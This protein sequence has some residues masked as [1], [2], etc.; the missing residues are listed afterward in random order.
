MIPPLKLTSPRPSGDN[1]L[2]HLVLSRRRA[3]VSRRSKRYAEACEQ[4]IVV[5][6]NA[7]LRIVWERAVEQ[8]PFY[9]MWADRHKLPS[10]IREVRELE[11]FPPLTKDDL[12][13]HHDLV[14]ARSSP[15]RVYSTGGSTGTPVHYPRG[16]GEALERYAG[17]FVARSWYGIEPGDPYV[18][19]WGASHRFGEGRQAVIRQ[20][21]R[22]LLNWGLGAVR[23]NAYDL[24]PEMLVEHA[25][26]VWETNPV[27]IAGYSSSVVR[28]ARTA[29]SQGL[30]HASL[31]RLKA[32]L[33]SAEAIS[34]VD[35]DVL[36]EVFGVP[37]I[38]E[39]GSAETGA[40]AVSSGDTWPL[41]V[42]WDSV[43]VT[44]G[45]ESEIHVT[46]L[47]SRAFPLINYRIGDRATGLSM[48]QGSALQIGRIEGR[49][50]D[51]LRLRREDGGQMVASAILPTHILKG[52]PAI[53]SV[54]IYCQNEHV[55]FYITADELLDASGVKDFF[56]T[57]VAHD[58]TVLDP[59]FLHVVQM[60]RPHLTPGGK[61]LLMI[62]RPFTYPN[63]GSHE[64]TGSRRD[65]T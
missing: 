15:A 23:L 35:I 34:D 59:T 25:R 41:R 45:E 33:V 51:D 9:R 43:A 29:R 61:Q 65:D 1:P 18:H 49:R 22:N 6:Q 20:W 13:E 44:P 40:I 21:R 56:L 32:V 38:N 50:Q 8:Q 42:L 10:R 3:A 30:D 63:V 31:T 28:V 55:T 53:A 62:T 58:G 39:Y 60:E 46:T 36:T 7:M 64:V 52:L 17:A 16:R 14:F 12:R 26:R 37:V 27:F 54:Q 19:L 47:H 4:D 11:G 5:E 57:Q 2:R 24:S 48:E